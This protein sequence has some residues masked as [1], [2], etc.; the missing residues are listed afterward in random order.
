MWPPCGWGAPLGSILV[1]TV[2]VHEVLVTAIHLFCFV[3]SLWLGSMCARVR[4]PGAP[5][6]GQ[7]RLS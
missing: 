4:R 1:P 7:C 6:W 5:Q 3:A 2:V